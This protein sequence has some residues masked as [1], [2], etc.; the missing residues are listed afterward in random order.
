[1][2]EMQLRP[3]SPAFGIY[4]MTKR[5]SNPRKGMDT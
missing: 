4:E 5:M 3:V 1:M 2:N